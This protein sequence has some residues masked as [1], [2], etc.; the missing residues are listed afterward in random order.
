M[1]VNETLIRIF[2]PQ[3][4][5]GFP[6]GGVPPFGQGVRGAAAPRLLPFPAAAVPRPGGPQPQPRAK[7]LPGLPSLR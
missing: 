1:Q 3:I 7:P 2:V 6:K 5:T 4:S